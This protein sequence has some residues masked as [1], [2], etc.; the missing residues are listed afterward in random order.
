MSIRSSVLVALLLFQQL[1]KPFETPWY[2]KSTR[3]VAMPDGQQLVV[4]AG[5]KVEVFA[6]KMNFPRAMVLA[7]NGDVF[8]SEPQTSNGR[9]TVLRDTNKDGIADVRETFASGLNRPFGLAF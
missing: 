9:I 4:P 5:F 3:V 1:P 7:P 2:R 6:E 8:V